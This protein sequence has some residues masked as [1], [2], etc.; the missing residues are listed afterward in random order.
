MKFRFRIPLF[1]FFA[2]FGAQILTGLALFHLK[3]GWT[4]GR[5]RAAFVNS[6]GSLSWAHFLET[7]VPHVVAIGT[8]TFILGHFL[9]F[10][11]ELQIS[12]RLTLSLGLLFAGILN[13]LSGSVIILWGPSWVAVK[14][15]TF[16]VFQFFLFA[17]T[18]VILKSAISS[19]QTGSS[20]RSIK[21]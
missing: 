16:C 14:L 9:A 7:A 3:Y 5:L 12:H 1:G 21:P 6:Q 15:L 4:F 17:V 13:S 11:P 19:L 18:V 8:I 2:L 10:V 20:I